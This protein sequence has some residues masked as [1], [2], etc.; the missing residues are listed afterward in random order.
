MLDMIETIAIE[1]PETKNSRINELEADNIVF[2]KNFSD[3]M[4]V[5][6]FIDDEWSLPR[7]IPFGNISI[8]PSM[9]A[10]H[11]GQTIFEGMKA[12]KSDSGDTL[13]FRPLENHKR[14]NLS[15]SRMCMPEMS[16]KFFMDALTTLLRLDEKWVLGNEGCSLYIR[17]FMFAT[18]EYIGVKASRNYRFMIITSP[19]GAYY[20]DPVKVMIE[21][22]YSRAFQGGVGFTKAAANYGV[23][24]Y[25]TKLAQEKG[26]QQ[27]IWTDAR[28]HKYIEESGMM[29]VMFVI[30]GT[31]VTP[32]ID[33]NTILS[34]NTRNSIVMIAKDWG[35]KVEER[36]V[37]VSEIFEAHR[38]GK[39]NEAFGVGTAAT[40]ANISTINHEGTDFELPHITPELFSKR[41]SV[42]LNDLRRG[43]VEDAHNWL[44]KI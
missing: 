43:R 44:Y 10:L 34:G 31:L 13:L 9:S 35:M 2:G 42:Y 30:D 33:S 22:K 24:L 14:L 36:K 29:N 41:V 18:D 17:P 12:H 7:I 3:H 21:T 28:D 15:A 16:E 5:A 23:S 25:P 11:Y 40:V 37:S 8:S 32:A 20:K 27:L 39:L 1:I 4:F 26:Y 19:S 38:N 6:D